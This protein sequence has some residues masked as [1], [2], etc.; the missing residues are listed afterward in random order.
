MMWYVL[1]GLSLSLA[2]VAGLQFFYMIYLERIDREQ[3]KRIHELERHSKHLS[4]RLSQAEQQIAE[5]D[6]ILENILDEFEDDE[7]EVWADVIE[8]R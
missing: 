2:A 1:I 3:K 4:K 8:D 7:E 6:E 5:Q